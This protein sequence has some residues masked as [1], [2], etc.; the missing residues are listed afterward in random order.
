MNVE[1]RK[2][3]QKLF[4]ISVSGRV[5]NV[6]LAC[7]T[8]HVTQIVFTHTCT[9]YY[10]PFCLFYAPS[11][12]H[13]STHLYAFMLTHTYAHTHSRT[14]PL[15]FSLSISL[16]PPPP[17]HTQGI[18]DLSALCQIM[19]ATFADHCPVYSKSAASQ[20]PSWGQQPVRPPATYATPSPYGAR[21]PYPQYPPQ[22]Q[23]YPGEHNN[24][25]S[26]IF[27]TSLNA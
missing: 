14:L 24:Q 17:T 1:C 11:Y 26:L 10:V 18:S 25:C 22:Q 8:A 5:H 2:S 21:P 13:V 20:Q 7:T 6:I 23:Q 9:L 15:S 16:T 3:Y 27:G 19:C 4:N 12:T